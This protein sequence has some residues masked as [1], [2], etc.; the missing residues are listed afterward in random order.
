MSGWTVGVEGWLFMGAWILGL[1]ILVLFLVREPRRRRQRDEA[2]E[3]LRRRFDRGE[4]SRDEF[5]AD[6]QFLES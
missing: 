6:V 3:T 1:L 2:L 5:E 4:I